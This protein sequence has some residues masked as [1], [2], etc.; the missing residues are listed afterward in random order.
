MWKITIL[1]EMLYLYYIILCVY[2][3]I[4]IM[5]D[6]SY[7]S[8]QIGAHVLIKCHVVITANIQRCNGFS[9]VQEVGSR[10]DMQVNHTESNYIMRC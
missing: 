7:S 8:Y 10:F 6:K 4:F 1:Y 2:I 3:Y 9:E 5:L